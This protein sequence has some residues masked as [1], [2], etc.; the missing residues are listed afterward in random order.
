MS[1]TTAT[2]T[3]E[4]KSFLDKLRKSGVTNMFGAA[5]YIQRQFGVNKADSRVILMEWMDSF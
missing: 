5:P 2:M 1:E 3:A 4:H